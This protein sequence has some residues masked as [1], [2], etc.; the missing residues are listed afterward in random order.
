MPAHDY[1]EGLP[2]YS[3]GQI[4]HDGCPECETRSKSRD[5]GIG[6]LDAQ[7]FVKA[8]QRAAAWNRHGVTDVSAA[9][10]PMLNVLWAIQLRLEQCG[11]NIGEVPSGF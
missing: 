6:I 2:G 11:I 7:R 1:H 4:L 3:A 9:E 8:W 10:R 5:L